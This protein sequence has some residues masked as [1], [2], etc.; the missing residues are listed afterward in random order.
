MFY[1]QA[2]VSLISANAACIHLSPLSQSLHQPPPPPQMRFSVK[3]EKQPRPAGLGKH[4]RRFYHPL[5]LPLFHLHRLRRPDL[6]PGKWSSSSSSSSSSPECAEK[7]ESTAELA[8]GAPEAPGG[9]PATGN[10]WRRRFPRAFSQLHHQRNHHHHHQP[11]DLIKEAVS[12]I[13]QISSHPTSFVRFRRATVEVATQTTSVAV[14]PA[15]Y[16]VP[17]DVRTMIPA[18]GWP[19]TDGWPRESEVPS[20]SASEMGSR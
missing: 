9:N 8:P 11:A 10:T 7:G 1:N 20:E 5:H 6:V 15:D 13:Q 4:G 16:A 18:N 17:A 3:S 19:M 2:L 12:R 14:L